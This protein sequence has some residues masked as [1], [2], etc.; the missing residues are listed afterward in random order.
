MLPSLHQLYPLLTDDEDADCVGGV[1]ERHRG[2][3]IDDGPGGQH[4]NDADR[5][6]GHP[7]TLVIVTLDPAEKNSWKLRKYLLGNL[8]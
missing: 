6:A 1:V 5:G 2:E 7:P 4:G 8:T 3:V